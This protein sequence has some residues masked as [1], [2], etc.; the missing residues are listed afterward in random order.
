M[1]ER[2]LALLQFLDQRVDA[3][4]REGIETLSHDL[5]VSLNIGLEFVTHVTHSSPPDNAGADRNM[6]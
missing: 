4:D 5:L 6:L 1:L 2:V 3:L